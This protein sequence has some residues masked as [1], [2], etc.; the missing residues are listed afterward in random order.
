[1]D[2]IAQSPILF[3]SP[4]LTAEE[5]AVVAMIDGLQ[6][7]LRQ[8]VR[9]PRRWVGSL[10]RV[11][12]ARSIQG[13]NSIE[14]YDA[15]LD[16]AAAIDLGQEPLDASEETALAL[17]GYRDAM[18]FVLQMVSDDQ[19]A[20]N[21]Q[22]LKSL[23]FMMTNHDLKA[24]PG[25]WRA[26]PIF[27]EREQTQEVVYEGASVALVRGL[28]AALV[29]TL[30]R[31][32]MTPPVVNAAMAHLNLVMIHP[33]RDGNGRMARCLQTLV[34]AR[35]GVVSPVFS[36]VEEYLGRNTQ[37]YYDVLALVGGGRWQ[38]GRDPR[39]WIRF[40]LLAHLRQARTML[41]RVRESERLW[42]EIERLM[43]THGLA[44]RTFSVL[45]EAAIGF[46]V[47]NATYRALLRPD[48]EITDATASRDLRQ[49][50]TV[51]LLTAVGE[52]RG[53]HYVASPKLRALRKLISDDRDPRDD[54]DPFENAPFPVAPG[55][56][57]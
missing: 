51:G 30:N 27:V 11:S 22:L 37:A 43:I 44:E 47:R 32:P 23:H 53:R 12:T 10:R 21:E 7:E 46:R 42:V 31:P 14:G 38:P 9:E 4:V 54:S 56:L 41:R 34:L 33:F 1:M 15:S 6:E 29:E 55:R 50:L 36:S 40:M 35:H 3:P 45:Y 19:F 16:D 39:P 5:L 24:R 17:R 8:S 28:V 52:N 2:G 13:S 20:Y 25:L 49:L 48:E 26:G 18:T 57:F